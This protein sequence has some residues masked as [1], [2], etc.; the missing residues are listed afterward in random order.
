MTHETCTNATLPV[1]TLSTKSI[2]ESQVIEPGLCTGCGACIAISTQ[3]ESVMAD[4]PL[5]PLPQFS[6]EDPP[7]AAVRVCP[8]YRLSYPDLYRSHYQSLPESWLLGTVLRT[9]TGHATNPDIRRLGASG[10]TLTAVLCHLL[11]TKRV[12][13][14]VAVRQGVPEP[15]L[16]R[17][18]LCHSVEDVLSCAQSVYVPVSVLDILR[19][20]EPGKRYAMTCLPDQ[21]AAL[22]ALQREGFGPAHQV[23]YVLGPYTGTALY[24]AAIR[25]YL[26]SKGVRPNDPITS[27]K[28]RAGEWPGYLEIKTQS[29]QIFRSNKVYYNFLIPFFITQ[30]SL[31]NMDFANEFS[32]LSVGDAW[33]PALEA[34]GQGFSVF[35]TRSQEMEDILQEMCELNLL[36][37]KSIDP[38]KASEMHGHMMDFK[39][40][41]G[42]IR[43]QFR[44][45]LGRPAPDYGF[46]P[47]PLPFSRI[48]V[49]CVI[50]SIFLVCRTRL[51]RWLLSLIPE[52]IIGPAFNRLRL[53]WKALSKPT[54]RKGLGNLTMIETHKASAKS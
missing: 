7:D 45:K 44:R 32:D 17:A 46:R 16:A 36:T 10:G 42:Y 8:A 12:D 53:G 35:T 6:G 34:Q 50:S 4:S 24:P 15:E 14:V 1:L 22:R 25:N 31:Q 26:R 19:Q 49:E 47:S 28:W 27:L 13:A 2:L 33:S 43:N 40:R 5:G 37:T 3:T 9:R 20:L 39:K 21:A 29:G 30:N 18:V 51:A 48:L 23:V 54:K 52:R 11:I 41:G 38:V